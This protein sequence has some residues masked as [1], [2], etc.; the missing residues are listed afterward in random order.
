MGSQLRFWAER[1]TRRLVFKRR[2][3][4]PFEAGRLYVTPA[5]RLGY[6]FRSLSAAEPMLLGWADV[7]VRPGNTVWD[8][9]ANIGL[10]AVAAAVRAGP[11]GR[12]VAFEPDL[13]LANLLRR[14]TALQSPDVA[15][16]AVMPLAIAKEPSIRKFAIATRARASNALA[17]YGASQMGGVVEHQL[18]PAFNLDSLLAYL[19]PPDV[20]KIDVEGAEFEVLGGQT[21][22]LEDVRP[23]ILCEVGREAKAGITSLLRNAR[24]RLF[25]AEKPLRPP[26][27]VDAATWNTLAIPEENVSPVV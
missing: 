18:V 27:P 3:P 15:P 12:V 1:L 7:L 9:G 24:Y 10:F 13:S 25:D 17:E 4:R 22:M 11:R 8:I 20:M 14:S 16:I 5:A 26:H 19:S 2:L 6:A 21:R 23:I